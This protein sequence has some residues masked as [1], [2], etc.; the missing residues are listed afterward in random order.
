MIPEGLIES[1]A[2]IHI[3]GF[4]LL[5][6]LESV[7]TQ[8]LLQQARANGALV[9]LDVI[10]VNDPLAMERVQCLLP[11]TVVVLPNRD[12]AALLT[13]RKNPWDQAQ[14]FRDAGASTVVITDGAQGA[15]ALETKVLE[16]PGA[17]VSTPYW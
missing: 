1:A 11:F 10:E 4:L 7:Q 8:E 17:W 9:V 3:G 16:G 14:M 12:E 13:G 6:A 5:D 2:V 15:W